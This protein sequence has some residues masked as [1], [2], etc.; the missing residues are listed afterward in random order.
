MELGEIDQIDYVYVLRAFNIKTSY[1]WANA[2]G[3]H[4]CLSYPHEDLWPLSD[5]GS[6]PLQLLHPEFRKTYLS[7]I[8]D[9]LNTDNTRNWRFREELAW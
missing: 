8:P 6:S 1:L 3:Y 4:V 9:F 2:L 7:R 5:I